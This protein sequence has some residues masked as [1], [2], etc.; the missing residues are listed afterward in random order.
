MRR[1]ELDR[2]LAEGADPLTSPELRWRARQLMLRRTRTRL[3]REIERVA[4]TPQKR[5]LLGGSAAPLNRGEISRCRDLLHS[6]AGELR[7]AEPVAPRGVALVENLLHDGHSPLYYTPATMER[8]LDA[9]LR[10]A[11]AALLLR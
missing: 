6:L 3:A 1:A 5:P 2:S 4:R 7:D 10:R 9:E 11:R 8:G